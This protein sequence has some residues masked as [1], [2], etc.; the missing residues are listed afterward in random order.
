MR[1]QQAP[2]GSGFGPATPAQEALGDT[3]LSGTLAIVTGGY[4]GLGL[5]TTRVLAEAGAANAGEQAVLGDITEEHFDITNDTNV[6][7]VL[8][9]VQ[10]APPLLSDRSSVILTASSGTVV[11]NPA[12]SVYSASKTAVRNFA[13]NWLLDLKGRSILVNVLSPGA[14]AASADREPWPQWASVW[15]TAGTP[16]PMAHSPLRWQRSQT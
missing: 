1:S 16:A 7:G 14:V 6:K 12:F 8:F 11:G 9:T 3:D 10:K 2:I 4:S 15:P 5:E 13:R